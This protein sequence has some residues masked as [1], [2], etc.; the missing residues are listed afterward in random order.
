MSAVIKSDEIKAASCG[1]YS[2]NILVSI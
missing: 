2:N 1:C